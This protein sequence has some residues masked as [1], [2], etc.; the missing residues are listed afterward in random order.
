MLFLL[1]TR[2][3]TVVTNNHNAIPEGPYPLQATLRPSWPLFTPGPTQPLPPNQHLYPG[4][5]QVR[6]HEGLRA[7]AELQGGPDLHR[8]VFQGWGG[9]HIGGKHQCLSAED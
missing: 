3:H 1:A 5:F 2:N 8:E 9:G 6:K 7:K 4:W